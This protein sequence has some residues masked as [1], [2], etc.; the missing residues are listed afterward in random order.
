MCTSIGSFHLICYDLD[1]L[2][3]CE[4]VIQTVPFVSHADQKLSNAWCTEF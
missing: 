1:S 4:V 2:S 3:L